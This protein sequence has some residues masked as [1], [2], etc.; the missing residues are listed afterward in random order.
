MN[1]LP[2]NEDMI[3]RL[4]SNVVFA[5]YQVVIVAGILLLPVG[6]LANQVGV[7]FPFHRALR[8]LAPAT[9]AGG[10]D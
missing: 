6:L 4:R 1:R 10:E 9:D 2:E 5:L 8:W 3:E 7:P